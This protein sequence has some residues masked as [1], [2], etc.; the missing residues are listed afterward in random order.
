MKA[1]KWLEPFSGRRKGCEMSIA[2]S[3]MQASIA[4]PKASRSGCHGIAKARIA[5]SS[6][7]WPL[8]PGRRALD[9]GCGAGVLTL[10]LAEKDLEVNGIASRQ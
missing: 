5:C 1:A 8:A 2:K 10:W 6:Q 3:V 9:L 4:R 7:L